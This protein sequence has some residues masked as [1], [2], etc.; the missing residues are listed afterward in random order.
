MQ[1]VHCSFIW[2]TLWKGQ[3]NT[4]LYLKVT[5][6]LSSCSSH[7]FWP[8]WAQWPYIPINTRV[9]CP[10][11]CVWPS[12]NAT[13]NSISPALPCGSPAPFSHFH[14]L[15][16]PS[17]ELLPDG[18]WA[19]LCHVPLSV[20]KTRRQRPRGAGYDTTWAANT[21][22]YIMAAFWEMAGG[23]KRLYTA[24][25]YKGEQLAQILQGGRAAL[26]MTIPWEDNLHY[27]SG[28]RRPLRGEGSS[29]CRWI[30][31]ADVAGG[32]LLSVMAVNLKF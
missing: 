16:F 30:C 31:R 2:Q 11:S 32:L 22:G 1:T 19:V 8:A 20:T 15:I 10:I 26:I 12:Q 13:G 29:R 24:A 18:V 14:L 21:W 4:E 25:E 3:N 6:L 5:R 23:W 28:E 9:P 17:C 7:L 27:I